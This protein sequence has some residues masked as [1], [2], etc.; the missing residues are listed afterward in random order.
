MA[1]S[2]FW[3]TPRTR[4][5]T[6]LKPAVA[7]T[8]YPRKVIMGGAPLTLS[9]DLPQIGTNALSPAMAP[10]RRPVASD[11]IRIQILLTVYDLFVME[12]PTVWKR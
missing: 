5:A 10:V 4:P 11:T 8:R 3:T 1:K 7:A 2:P 6:R 9:A 12:V